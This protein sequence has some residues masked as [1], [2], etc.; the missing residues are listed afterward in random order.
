MVDF[1]IRC[2]VQVSPHR[3][4]PEVRLVEKLTVRLYWW[5]ELGMPYLE[6]A[7]AHSD[8]AHYY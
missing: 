5:V 8:D 4:P 1:Q 2:S 3:D 6:S 7:T